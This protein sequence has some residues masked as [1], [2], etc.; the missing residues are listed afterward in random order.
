MAQAAGGVGTPAVGPSPLSRQ[1]RGMRRDDPEQSVQR[2]VVDA[3]ASFMRRLDDVYQSSATDPPADFRER[4]DHWRSVC[5]LP[6]AV[7]ARMHRLRIW[8]NASEHRDQRRWAQ[9]GP[10]DA[11]EAA[12]FFREIDVSVAALETS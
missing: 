7:H 11:A 12:G 8:R 2:N 1:V 10:R 4:L 6:E 5:G 9:E 3:F